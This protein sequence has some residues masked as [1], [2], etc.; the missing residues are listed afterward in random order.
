MKFSVNQETQLTG[1][2]SIQL[3]LP[4]RINKSNNKLLQQNYKKKKKE[5]KNVT[6]NMSSCLF[7]CDHYM[8]E[9][10]PTPYYNPEWGGT[11]RM[12]LKTRPT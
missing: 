12:E 9:Y 6:R 4:N 5:K 7:F 3:A 10:M 8:Y 11:S 2:F 1:A